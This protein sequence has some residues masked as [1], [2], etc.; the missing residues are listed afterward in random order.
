MLYNK[1][2]GGLSSYHDLI[3]IELL[4]CLYIKNQQ[5]NTKS[6]KKEEEGGGGGGN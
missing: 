6:R 2:R 4:V 5:E 3:G 1:I